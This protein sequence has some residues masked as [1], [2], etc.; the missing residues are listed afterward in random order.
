MARAKPRGLY[1]RLRAEINPE[2]A[3]GNLGCQHPEA[4]SL[5]NCFRKLA[6]ARGQ[7]DRI[8]TIFISLN[9]GVRQLQV[10]VEP[11]E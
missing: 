3:Q 10:F 6:V 11:H 8:N 7:T 1:I 2:I 9:F 4:R 5:G